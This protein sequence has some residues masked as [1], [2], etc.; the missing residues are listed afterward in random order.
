M[1]VWDNLNPHKS[2]R[3]RAFIEATDWLSAVHLPA[4]APDLNPVEGLWSLIK[5]GELANLAVTGIDHLARVVRRPMHRLQHRPEVLMG[6]LAQTGLAPI[7][8]TDITK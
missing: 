6:L 3:M 8:D 4:Y 1:L 7:T 5:R 2:A